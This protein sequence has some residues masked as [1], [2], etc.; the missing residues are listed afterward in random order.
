[1]SNLRQRE[2]SPERNPMQEDR[3]TPWHGGQAPNHM[4]PN[5]PNYSTV[6]DTTMDELV[7]C[8]NYRKVAPKPKFPGDP[9]FNAGG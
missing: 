5:L 4:T 2:S 8:Y 9:E 7:H 6:L 1:M 3:Q